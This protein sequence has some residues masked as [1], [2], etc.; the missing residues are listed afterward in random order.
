MTT[1]KL[2]FPKQSQDY[3]QLSRDLRTNIVFKP[4]IIGKSKDRREIHFDFQTEERLNILKP[5]LLTTIKTLKYDAEE[6]TD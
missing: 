3:K 2:Y 5:M 6:L 4:F 1:L